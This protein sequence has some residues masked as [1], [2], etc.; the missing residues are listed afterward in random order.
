MAL[1]DPNILRYGQPMDPMGA[2]AQG[3]QARGL[4]RQNQEAS[5]QDAFRQAFEQAAQGQDLTSEE[6]LRATLQRTAQQF[7]QES[8]D[9]FQKWQEKMP[10]A[11]AA[12]AKQFQE[13]GN[14][15]VVFDPSTG[16]AQPIPGLTKADKPK[17]PQEVW[18][19][20]PDAAA[21]TLYHRVTGETKKLGLPGKPTKAD[22]P[23]ELKPEQVFS[24]EQ[25]L[26]NQFIGK[27]KDFR[28][29][30]DAYG[31]IQV[32]AKD[33]SAAG[34]LALIFNYMKMLDPGSTVREGEFATAQNAGG[35]PERIF[36]S[37]NKALNG[38]RLAPSQ[39]ADFLSRAK[40]LYAQQLRQYDKAKFETRKMASAYQGLNPDR[41]LMDDGLAED[42]AQPAA[43]SGA[44]PTHE[45]YDSL[46]SGAEFTDPE[47]NVRRK[48]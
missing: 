41:I 32:S 7:P 13:F 18:A 36:S 22:K 39:R 45:Q 25:Q 27:T 43:P 31:R 17:D 46:P 42:P 2:L 44:M 47:G 29:V 28:D 30:R 11:K 15:A 1:V 21:P 34:D 23:A 16:Q 38:E 26:R 10:K 5:R 40:G 20:L 14:Q 33:P 6:G 3:F 24:M 19:P 9:V 12:P 35:I 37:Y 8:L 48:P 4:I